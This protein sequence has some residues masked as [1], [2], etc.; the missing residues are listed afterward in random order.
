MIKHKR[1]QKTKRGSAINYTVHKYDTRQTLGWRKHNA[2]RH[3]E[4]SEELSALTVR[5]TL[6]KLGRGRWLFVRKVRVAH[7]TD[8]G[9]YKEAYAL[10]DRG[11]IYYKRKLA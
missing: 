4:L 3:I 10:S 7:P 8:F 9:Y 2:D 11:K 5:G 1:L 6:D